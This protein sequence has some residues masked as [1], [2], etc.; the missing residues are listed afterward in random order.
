MVHNGRDR[1]AGP[2]DPVSPCVERPFTSELTRTEQALVW[3]NVYEL[4]VHF[5]SAALVRVVVMGQYTP[6]ANT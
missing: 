6:H 1:A 2:M 3:V 4:D 5:E